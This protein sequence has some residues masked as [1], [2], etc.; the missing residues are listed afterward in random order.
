MKTDISG[1][2]AD[3]LNIDISQLP[4]KE[5]DQTNNPLPS[6][7]TDPIA[8]K[9]QPKHAF[10][11]KKILTVFLILSIIATSAF[12]VWRT[13]QKFAN[14][15]SSIKPTIAPTNTP[16]PTMALSLT[17]EPPNT[18]S[19]Q[20]LN[21]SGVA[22]AA[23][24]MQKLLQENKY[25]VQDVG[26]ATDYELN[27]TRIYHKATIP[28]IYLN[29]LDSVLT[30]TYNISSYEAGLSIDSTYDIQIIIGPN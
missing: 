10:L 20:I 3:V 11:A 6:T 1:K 9:T 24:K 13:Y 22:G 19:I 25:D 7:P 21:G 30:D 27:S 16:E 17:P 12:A 15:P 26:N 18:Y 4:P 23:G 28:Q 5:I 2:D 29:I 8:D 14:P